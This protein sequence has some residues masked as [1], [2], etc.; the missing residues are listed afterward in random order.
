[1]TNSYKTKAIVIK[2]SNFG[3]ADR[4][5][6]IF[7]ERFGKIKALAKGVRKIRSHM[8]G[9]LEPFQLVDLQLHE[10]KTFQIVTGA[11]TGECF[12]NIHSDL[13]KTSA[14]FYV[15]ELIDKFV[16][17]KQKLPEIFNLYL[18]ILWTIEDS[19]R[20]L[21]IRAFELKLIE[22]AGF[23]PELYEC[24]HCKEKIS[25]GENF[26]DAVEGGLICNNCQN[27]HHHGALRISDETIKFLR[28]VGKSDLATVGRLKL[29]Q[30]TEDEAGEILEKYLGNLL[31]REIKSRKF[32]DNL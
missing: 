28:F 27:V 19:D 32:M 21:L 5:L 12:P 23:N 30:E 31:E 3:E 15:S 9:S 24:V 22:A 26:W 13:P 18:E 2:G 20:P 1:M 8:A 11:V 10:G 29:S 7:T 25:P 6:T 14:A 4:I 17:E 16:E